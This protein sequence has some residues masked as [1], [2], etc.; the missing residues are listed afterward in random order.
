MLQRCQTV[1]HYYYAMLICIKYNTQRMHIVH[2]KVPI[3]YLTNVV[4]LNILYHIL[5]IVYKCHIV[6]TSI[7]YLHLVNC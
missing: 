5:L 4:I 3:L 7:A 1:T 2:I 6:G